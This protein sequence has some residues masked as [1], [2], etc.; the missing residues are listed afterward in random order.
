MCLFAKESPGNT[1]AGAKPA[2]AA[3]S[4]QQVRAKYPIKIGDTLVPKGTVGELVS[5]S[6]VM[7]KFPGIKSDPAS[8]FVA[9][10]F[11]GLDWCI[12]PRKQVEA[13]TQSSPPPLQ[14]PTAPIA[15]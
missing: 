15:A 10:Q 6:V 9:V 12:I 1:D 13:M 8:P 11:P 2:P 7:I 5:V 3:I 14:S 4:M